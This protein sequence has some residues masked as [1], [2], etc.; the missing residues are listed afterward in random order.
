MNEEKT[1]RVKSFLKAWHTARK[2]ARIGRRLFH[3]LR[4]SAVRNLVRSGVPE[5]VAMRIS[6][7]RTRSIF[8]RYNITNEDDLKQAA[9]KLETH[10]QEIE[11]TCQKDSVGTNPGTIKEIGATL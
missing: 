8:Q 11:H 10:L 4:R 3:D 2:K 1:D 6:G 7:H 5:T 9:Q